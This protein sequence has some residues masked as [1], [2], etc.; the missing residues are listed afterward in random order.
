MEIAGK[1]IPMMANK[2]KRNKTAGRRYCFGSDRRIKKSADF[3]AVFDSGKKRSDSRLILFALPNHLD[4]SRL[5]L[6]VGKKLGSAVRRNRYKRALR[7]AFRLQQYDLPAGYDFVVIPRLVYQE[8]HQK[9][10]SVA[11]YG[12]SL[13]RLTAKIH[14]KQ[15]P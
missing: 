6:A 15:L 13:I 11:E 3:A 4:H 8:E 12:Q 2:E 9:I 10:D 5:G 14:T 7:E 1:P